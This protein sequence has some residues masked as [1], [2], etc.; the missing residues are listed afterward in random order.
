M[1]LLSRTAPDGERLGVVAADGS[2]VDVA[3]LLGDGP[4]TMARLLGA[5]DETLDALRG[6]VDERLD[7]PNG[8]PAARAPIPRHDPAGVRLL[9]PVPHPSKI[10]A[11]G[12]N[13]HEHAAEEGQAAPTDPIVFTKFP[14]ALVGDGADIVWRAADTGQVD[15]EAELAVVVGRR[16]KD[17]PAERALEHVLGYTCCN[18]VS[19]RDLQFGDGQ[20]VRGKSLDTFCPLGP[21]IVTTDEIP[22]PG[23]LAIRCLV[24]DEVVQDASTAAMVHG[25]AELI[26]FCSR[27]MTLEPGDVI[28]TGTP[29][30]VGVFRQPP[31]FLEDGDKVVVEIEGIG[32]LT[33]RCR[34]VDERR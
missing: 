17:V 22:D 4:W 14:S 5:V 8:A 28:A 9:A 33:N 21:W 11:V 29:A 19:A 1:R 24:N 6:A 34:V 25:V 31:R 20:W 7:A 26:A 30:G 3:D 16:A 32:R 12:R 27:F 23:A 15:Y 10:V 13:Y 18:D 2:V